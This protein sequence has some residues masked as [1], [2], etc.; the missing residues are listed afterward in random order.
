MALCL[1][2]QVS[3]LSCKHKITAF[4]TGF[5]SQVN[6]PVG[7][8]DHIGV[9]LDHNNRMALVDQSIKR[10]QQFFYIMKMKSGSGLIKNEKDLSGRSYP[11]RGK[12]PASPF[13][14]LL[15]KVYQTTV[16]ASHNPVPLHSMDGWH[17]KS[18]F[19]FKKFNGF[20]HTQLQHLVNILS[21]VL[22]FKHFF[23]EFFSLAYL[24][25][26]VNIGKELHFNNFFAFTFAGIATATIHIKRKMFW[27]KTTHLAERL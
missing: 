9:V 23:L 27:L 7:A 4:S 13:V 1:F 15:P 8:F 19:I 16:R 6:Y 14:L 3:G 20:I 26:Q 5:R 21:L 22:Y 18:F 2:F 17:W 10:S 25:G 24:A 12:K 11:C